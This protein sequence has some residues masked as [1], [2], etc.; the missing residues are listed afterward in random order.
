MK[1]FRLLTGVAVSALMMAGCAPKDYS[2]K[3]NTVT[4]KVTS[5]SGET[6]SQVRLQVLGEK[7]I[8]VSA[9]PDGAFHDRPS[10]VVLPQ[11]GKVPFSVKADSGTVTVSTAA[12]T[13]AIRIGDGNLRF[14][15]ADG[16][17]FTASGT[18][19]GMHF[20]P[21]EVE[22]KRAY[23]TQVVFDSPEDEAFYGLGQQQTGEFNHK[24]LNEELYQYNT[25]ISIPFV[26][27]SRGYGLLFD[28]Y[29]LSRWGNPHPTQQL[30]RVFRLWDMDGKEGA[31]TGT[32][33]TADGKV[34]V[35]RE[36]SLYYEN[37]RAIGLLPALKYK[38]ARVTYEG[39]L[40]ATQEA[41]YYFTQYYAGFQETELDGVPVMTRRWRPAW[42]PNS[43]RYT[44]HFR[45]GEKKHL[46][47]TWEPDGDV[48][49]LSLKVAVPQ[50]PAEQDRLS[51][52]SE[53]EPQ[54]DFYFLAGDNYDEVIHGYRTLT[55]KAS[56]FPRWSLGFWQSRER[57]TTQEEIVGALK[58]L[59]ARHI[60]VDNIVQDWQY[61]APDQWGSH[62]FEAS[63]FPEPEAMLDSIHALH[64]RYMISVWP[65][66][67][68]NTEHYQ[69][70]KAAGYA[71][72]HAEDTAI[73][74]WLGHRLSFYDA[75]APGGRKMFWD[76]IDRS[77]YS[78]YGRKIDAWWM[79]ASEPNLRD[80]LPMDYLKWL[81]TPTA[82]GPSTEYLNAYSL[83]N[84][85]AIYN[86]QRSVDP[87]KR[88]FLLTRNGFAGL[89]RYSTASWSGDIGT[90]WTD[91]RM[92][93]AAGL[94][95]SMAGLPMWGMDI[96]G[97]SVMDKFS[98]AMGE[99]LRT[100]KETP[101]MK[102]WRELQT[103][104]HQ[105]GTFV[106]LFRT[107]G[108]WPAREL[109]NIAP[110]G[111]P[112]YESILWYMQLR[113]RLMP[114]L[115]SLAGAVHFDDYT[116]LRGL[117]MDFPADAQVTDLSDQWML[118][119]AF[120]PCPVYE[121]GARSRSV[122]FPEGGWYDFYT[123]RHIAGGQRLSVDAPYSRMP[124]YV[125][126]GSIVPVGPAMEWSNEK[127]ADD[128]LLAVYAGR[129]ARFVLYEDENVNYG[130]EKGRFARIPLEWDEGS[131]TLTVGPRE[132]SFPGMLESRRF[133][134][135]VCDPGHPFAYDPDA[136][137]TAIQYDG[138]AQQIRL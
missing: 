6:P 109:W 37:E 126:E 2:V 106:P 102:E 52:W 132:G 69:E 36:D 120:M 93:M 130:Y 114:Y 134:V 79:D 90:S 46:K 40:E 39:Y 118:G 123:G 19:P 96:G 31:L 84:A 113:Y 101:D 100:G 20:T 49:Y 17:T 14:T 119:P 108:Q 92:Q 50:T 47:L 99:Y 107:H 98:A 82:L 22:G 125:R 112:A 68:T 45:K 43:C 73:V 3:G 54:I 25:K 34:L 18:A 5:L 133:R 64:A 11:K 86:G 138:T 44:V 83:V 87:D 103:R 59:R 55:G 78:R 48:S 97:F 76:Q 95:Y 16:K 136:P 74:D 124:L 94:N 67:Y 72:T 105:M 42:N 110:E 1:I 63:R 62:E 81:L 4:V 70:L 122:W 10:L 23:S 115:Y 88:V 135:V 32:Y 27:S 75:Y 26:V 30:G 116:L 51:F 137:G 56:L 9:T 111:S 58:E 104:W 117:P 28:A 7:I 38:G 53:F 21:I 66:F 8:R 35:Q 57:Y 61:W 77:L 15:G 128:I 89:Q 80:C 127:Q 13:A 121:Y 129:D 41:D 65:K 33:R 131:R 29:S 91:M 71:Y 12:L 85:D 24:G 60:P